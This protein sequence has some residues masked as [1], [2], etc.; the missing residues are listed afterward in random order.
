MSQLSAATSGYE[1]R[2]FGRRETRLPAIVRIN[3]RTT[4]SCTVRDVSEGGALLEFSEAVELP[5]RIRLA[6]D[7]SPNDIIC[8]VRHKRGKLAGVQFTGG[9]LTIALR[10]IVDPADPATRLPE[11]LPTVQTENDCQRSKDLAELVARLRRSLVALAAANL[12]V[13]ND[14]IPRDISVMLVS[15]AREQIVATE[16]A[17]GGV[18]IELSEFAALVEALSSQRPAS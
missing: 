17:S 5:A 2:A 16:A 10:H 15:V 13:K 12:A 4:V 11:G 9:N 14:A 6:M 3:H 8:D 1:R 18:L 7:S